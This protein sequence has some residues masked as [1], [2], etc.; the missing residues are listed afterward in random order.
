MY[1]NEGCKANLVRAD[2]VP[3]ELFKGEKME[4]LLQ[5]D[6]STDFSL[7]ALPCLRMSVNIV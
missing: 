2:S 6:G 3:N 1:A 4:L 5:T 7:S